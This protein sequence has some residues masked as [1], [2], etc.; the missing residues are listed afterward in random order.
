MR[1][2]AKA[3]FAANLTAQASA[4][5]RYVVLAR[6][7]GPEQLGLAALLIL[8]AQ[9]FESISDT[10][11]D[12]IL[13]QDEDGD[14]PR[15]QGLAHAILAARGV[16]IALSLLAVSGTLTWLDRAPDLRVSLLGFALIPLVGGFVHLDTRRVQRK[17]DFR[18]ESAALVVSE[19]LSLV[20]TVIAAFV[21]R[22]HTAVVYGLLV[23]A[24]ALVAVSH[25]TAQRPY[26]W[27]F[28]VPEARRFAAFAAPLAANGLLL[29]LG[30]QGDRLLIAG[31]LGPAALGQYSAILLLIFYP[32]G[33]L[34]KF[35][36]N[37]HLP[38]LANSRDDAERFEIETER[39]ASRT[40]LL[41]LAMAVGFAVVAPLATPALYGPSFAKPLQIFA[42]LGVL[43]SARFLRLWPTV[44]AVSIGRT[45]IV[46]LNNVARLVAIPAALAANLLWPSLEAIVSGFI[47]GE[48]VALVVALTLVSRA[49]ATPL[50]RE[51]VRAAAFLIG[52][53]LV[54]VWAWTLQARELIVTPILLVASLLAA[55]VLVRLE[56]RALTEAWGA[57]RLRLGRKTG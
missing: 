16:L 5:I 47:L 24:A 40:L 37:L 54:V 13:I 17:A 2:G 56:R 26:R 25:L 12:R 39:L 14:S 52:G 42:L 31:N 32:S 4:L 49:S 21:T 51:V 6:L 20:A 57:S 1:K 44:L 30:S 55:A 18:P 10:G 33:A 27:A 34:Q 29:F 48:M 3:Y 45:T 38:S 8:T 7:I 36:S 11:S 15:L 22:D 53:G 28:G 50:R 43:Q 41:A 9:F 23:R 35:L 46:M 19:V